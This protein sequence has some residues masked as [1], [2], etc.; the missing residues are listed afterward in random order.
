[1]IAQPSIFSSMNAS[2]SLS[3]ILKSNHHS[4]QDVLL[5]TKHDHHHHHH[6]YLLQNHSNQPLIIVTSS[7]LC[8]RPILLSVPLNHS[9]RSFI[10]PKT[11]KLPIRIRKR[12]RVLRHV[13]GAIAG[14]IIPLAIDTL[15]PSKRAAKV[16]V[17]NDALILEM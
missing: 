15:R 9:T 4:S 8:N 14:A 10:N 5:T 11:S 7:V 13:I 17:G 1:M 16:D 3:G 12:R 2:Q 6:K